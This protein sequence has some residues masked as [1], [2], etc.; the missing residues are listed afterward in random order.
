VKTARIILALAALL[1]GTVGGAP[2]GTA[3]AGTQ[4]CFHRQNEPLDGCSMCAAT[5][6]GAGYL[7]CAI[8]PG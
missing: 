6:L 3:L 5:C 1:A 2:A 7:C 8:I 4:Q